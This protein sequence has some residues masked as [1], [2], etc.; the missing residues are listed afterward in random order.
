MLAKRR[1]GL[2]SDLQSLLLRLRTKEVS[3]FFIL[4]VAFFTPTVGSFH[5][6]SRKFSG[7]GSAVPVG[8]R[9]LTK[10]LWEFARS[11]KK[12]FVW[13]ESTV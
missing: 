1:P 4:T 5:P 6:H 2:E 9:D 11:E 7:L 3:S 12:L 13:L 10:I 8:G